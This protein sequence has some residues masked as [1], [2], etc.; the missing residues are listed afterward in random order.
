MAIA[1]AGLIDKNLCARLRL[2][3][4]CFEAPARASDQANGSSEKHAPGAS[5]V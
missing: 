2:L 3:D 1:E 5:P 4:R